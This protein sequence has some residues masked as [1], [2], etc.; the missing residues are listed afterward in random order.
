MTSNFWGIL[1]FFHE[2]TNRSQDEFSIFSDVSDV[3]LVKI[4]LILF[5][6]QNPIL[7]WFLVPRKI[8]Y[9]LQ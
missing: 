8:K 4:S 5:N 3:R 7:F 2:Q 6:A 9:I 1:D